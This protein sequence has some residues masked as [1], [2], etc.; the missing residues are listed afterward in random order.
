LFQQRNFSALINDTFTFFKVTGKNYFRNYLLINGSVLL[1]LIIII[2]LF[3]KVFYDLIFSSFDNPDAN[4][5]IEEYFEGNI[6]YIIGFGGLS[7]LLIIILTL[8]SYSFPVF[9][10]KAFAKNSEPST[11]E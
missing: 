4:M 8:L 11:K 10:M 1:L 2:Y 7:A 6:G 3:S 9:Y 5:I